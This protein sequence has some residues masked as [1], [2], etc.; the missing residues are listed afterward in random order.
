MCMYVYVYEKK[1]E[2]E[3]LGYVF[4]KTIILLKKERNIDKVCVCVWEG[5]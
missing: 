4:I 3:V 2:S 1:K 5:G